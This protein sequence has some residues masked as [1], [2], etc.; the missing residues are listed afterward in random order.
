MTADPLH[1]IGFHANHIARHTSS[2]RMQAILQW[3]G[4]GSVVMM[5][6]AATVHLFRD[7]TKPHADWKAEPCGHRKQRELPG[8]VSEDDARKDRGR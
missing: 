7:L 2:E 5:G 4:V 1:S 3:V 6:L 8:R